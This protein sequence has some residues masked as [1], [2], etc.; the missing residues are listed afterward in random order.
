MLFA[1]GILHDS[2]V[3]KVQT[4]SLESRRLEAWHG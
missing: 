4:N 2:L 1:F 3:F